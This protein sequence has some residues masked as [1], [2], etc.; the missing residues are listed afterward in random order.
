MTEEYRVVWCQQLPGA[1]VMRGGP[2]AS[3]MVQGTD[4]V[5]VTGRPKSGHISITF[6]IRS[7]G[8]GITDIEAKI[9]PENYHGILTS[10]LLA[11]PSRFINEYVL[12]ARNIEKFVRA[13]KF[14]EASYGYEYETPY[15]DQN[16][17]DG[18]E[19]IIH[20]NLIA[21]ENIAQ[22]SSKQN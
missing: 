6:A 7:K 21:F 20:T 9:I 17:N 2:T 13:K 8:G 5:Y 14:T 22:L 4:K 15:R 12:F 19:A 10:M 16:I 18:I 3:S 1:V 11:D